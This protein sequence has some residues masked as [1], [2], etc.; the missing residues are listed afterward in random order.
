MEDNKEKNNNASTYFS[1]AVGHD[2]R[3]KV[4]VFKSNSS[5]SKSKVAK[6]SQCFSNRKPEPNF[7]C[8]IAKAQDRHTFF[9]AGRVTK[10]I[11]FM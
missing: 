3:P 1:T 11:S 5:R 6:D 2:G 10:I 9:R 7:P 8:G 4:K